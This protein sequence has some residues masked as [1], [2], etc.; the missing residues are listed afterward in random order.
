MDTQRCM[1]RLQD[2]SV[3][4]FG[5]SWVRGRA[6]HSKAKA[7][8][9]AMT[10]RAWSTRN[11]LYYGPHLALTGVALHMRSLTTSEVRDPRQ[12]AVL[13]LRAGRARSCF[14]ELMQGMFGSG[15]TLSIAGAA[16]TELHTSTQA[17][18]FSNS[19][20]TGSYSDRKHSTS[21]PFPLGAVQTAWPVQLPEMSSFL[22]GSSP[23]EAPSRP[24]APEPPSQ[25]VTSTTL[26]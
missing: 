4:M 11:G 16:R 6:T 19:L 14:G 1:S 5:C 8:I 15:L 25:N 2:N 24:A 22:R 18:Y 20:Q 23:S 10:R 3:K 7:F 12:S 13:T 9:A 21:F 17:S 26:R